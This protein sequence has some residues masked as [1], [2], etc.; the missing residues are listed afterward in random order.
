M[1]RNLAAF[2]F[3]SS[4]ADRALIEQPAGQEFTERAHSAVFIG[5]PGT[6]KAHL[7]TTVGEADITK[8]RRRVWFFSTVVLSTRLSENRPKDASVG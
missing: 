7:A 6:G 1:H 8:R 4:R 5:G 3:E 2:G